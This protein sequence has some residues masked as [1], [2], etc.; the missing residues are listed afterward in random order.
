MYSIVFL[1]IF[2]LTAIYSLPALTWVSDPVSANE[3]ATAYGG[4]FTKPAVNICDGVTCRT[5]TPVQNWEQSVKFIV[6]D[7]FNMAVYQIRV[8]N[9]DGSC[10]DSMEINQPDIWWF[11]SDGGN[12]ASPGGWTRIFG[13]SLA[14]NKNRCVLASS[15]EKSNTQLKIVN[16]KT[17]QLTILNAVQAS[18]YSLTFV[19]PDIVEGVYDV[20][21]NNGLPNSGWIMAKASLN[22][23]KPQRWSTMVFN[24]KELG[25]QNALAKVEANGGGIV[26]F[27]RGRYEM[28]VKTITLPPYTTLKGEGQEL[29]N[30]FWP[31]MQK[32]MAPATLISGA[33]AFAIEDLSIYVQLF[34]NN[35]IEDSSSSNGVRIQRVRIR[36][37]PLWSLIDEYQPFRGRSANF[38][39]TECGV[40]VSLRGVNFV[41]TDND[42]YCGGT[43]LIDFIYSQYGVVSNN[44]INYGSRSYHFQSTS[45]IIFEKNTIRGSALSSMG[46]DVVTFFNTSMDTL[47]F[48][49]NTEEF[50]LG[51]DREMMTLDG[52]GG[53]Y[54]GTLANIQGTKMTLSKDPEFHNYAPHPT[55]NYARGAFMILSGQ[56]A[57][58]YR[59]VV[60][61]QGREWEIDAPWVIEPIV[62]VS[63]INIGPFKG[64]MLFI[65]N[66]FSDGGSVQLYAMAIDIIVAENIGQR[67]NGFFSWGLNPHKWGWQPNWFTQF[68]DNTILEGNGWG[69]FAAS[70]SSI[71]GDEQPG[72]FSGPMNNNVI[73]RRNVLHSNANIIIS[74]TSYD[75]IVENNVIMN[76]ETGITVQNTTKQVYLRGNN[77]VQVD[78]CISEVDHLLKYYDIYRKIKLV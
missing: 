64:R 33:S 29:V 53:A 76:T 12:T 2:S 10:T 46:N 9:E 7:T 65:N 5:V 36:A 11:Q 38:S 52:G 41:V 8:C 63:G 25:L 43:H 77:C 42:F 40:C 59:R 22:I 4:G 20:Y 16:Q 23:K 32:D 60:H 27:P 51:A 37:N 48:S 15:T 54:W 56:G 6:P 62:N 24:V 19:I 18:C 26:Y 68:L 67:F 75:V 17:T 49:Q 3:T 78:T 72:N 13:K 39:F 14:F 58:Q 61:N 21:V 50:V 55:Q 31:D 1:F 70:L 28:P 57:G 35:I 71:T 34:F 44:K 45:Y 74:G 66:T 30:L 73:M 47:F 69:H